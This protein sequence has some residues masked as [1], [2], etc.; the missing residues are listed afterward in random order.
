MNYR[1]VSF[2]FLFACSTSKIVDKVNTELPIQNPPDIADAST[3]DVNTNNSNDAGMLDA[4]DEAEAM[5]PMPHCGDPNMPACQLG[6]DCRSSSDCNSNACDYTNHCIAYKSC[7]NHFGGDTCGSLEVEEINAVHETCC[8][9][10]QVNGYTDNIHANQTVYVDKYEIT[11]GRMRAFVNAVIAE[12]GKPDFKAWVAKHH[13]SVWNDN[14]TQFLPSDY[15]GDSITISRFLLGDPRHIGETQAQAGPG[16]VLVPDTDQVIS[17]GLD[18]QFNGQVFADTHGN[19]CGT[20]DGSYGFPTF[21]YP[22]NVLTAAGEVARPNPIGFKGQTIDAEQALDVKS[23]NCAS[24]LMFQLFCSFDGGQ[25]ATSEVWDY[26][27]ATPAR[28]LDVSGCGVQYSNH[29]DLLSNI[30][31]TSV[32]IGGRCAAAYG[33]QVNLF[34][35]AGQALPVPGSP[36]NTNFYHYPD[37]GTATNDKSWIVAAPGRMTGDVVRTNPA[38]EGWYDLAGNLTET[39]LETVNGNFDGMF[40]LRGQGVG[41]GSERSDLNVYQLPL[42]VG[43][44]PNLFTD[45]ADQGI[46]RVQRPE[47]KSGLVGSRCMY[48]K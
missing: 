42:T 14:W 18:H 10:L 31:T 41:F 4:T 44:A 45:N 39:V 29:A 38:D 15:E 19:N 22:A 24:N 47:V 48:F 28:T 5:A 20:Y 26:I 37:Y 36:L 43:T 30:T 33:G 40:S 6:E 35:D 34:F 8:K 7:V 1:Y 21:W 27:T 2:L 32:F 3:V 23:M 11:A 9:P 46:I 25:L 12:F 13:P 17:T 16:V